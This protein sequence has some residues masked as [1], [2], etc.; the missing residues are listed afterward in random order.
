MCIIGK[1]KVEVN[2]S[3]F[4]EKIKKLTTL[5]NKNKVIAADVYIDT[6]DPPDLFKIRPVLYYLINRF[7]EKTSIIFFNL[8][9]CFLPDAEEHIIN[10]ESKEKIKSDVCEHCK[11]NSF[12]GG[13]PEKHDN[14]K[15]KP[16]KDRP[17][18]V[19]LELTTECNLNCEFCFNKTIY[20]R[21]HS[22]SQEQAISVINQAKELGV[23][24]IRFTG[25][26]PVL[27]N[28]L[29]ELVNHAN[30]LGMKVW[31]NTNGFASEKYTGRLL[32]GVNSLLIP[33]HGIEIDSEITG[34]ADS[35]KNKLRTIRRIK[36]TVSIQL[37]IGTAIL[38]KNLNEIESIYNLTKSLGVEWEL[39]RLIGNDKNSINTPEDIIKL[40]EILTN[41]HKRYG[42]RI[43]M[44]NAFPF[45]FFANMN[46]ARLFSLG[47][48]LDDGADR[49]V[50]NAKGEASP[51][52]YSHEKT[53]NW[54]NLKKAWKNKEA[55]K[56]RNMDYLP[57]K[58]KN[59]DYRTICRGGSRTMAKNI[60]GSYF[61]K[62]PLLKEF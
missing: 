51:T 7:E 26:E 44:T 29:E 16:V 38:S 12:C 46:K 59:C 24:R 37:R 41:I 62:D 42:E 27:H 6:K 1:V 10:L 22:L 40:Y 28:G 3:D 2:K 20:N 58:C 33:L 8:P 14:F 35:L 21:R 15:V 48:F 56:L 31:L 25:G 60:S 49:V 11:F 18:E 52:Y 9:Y 47:G 53:G 55:K 23:G 54:R 13:F 4:A 36:K 34:K 5:L 43:F 17:R 50:I 45:C 39:Y 32:K 19:S 57:R 61:A 30:K